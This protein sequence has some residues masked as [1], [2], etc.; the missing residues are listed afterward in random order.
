VRTLVSLK[1]GSSP[2]AAV[3]LSHSLQI[4]CSPLPSCFFIPRPRRRLC[5]FAFALLSSTPA[6]PCTPWL[7]SVTPI[8]SSLRRRSTWCVACSGGVHQGSPEGFAPTRLPSATLPSGSSCYSS[9]T[10]P[11][12]WRYRS[13]LS[14]YCCW[15]SSSSSFSTL[16]P[17][18]SSKQPSLSRSTRCS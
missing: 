2:R 3:T 5:H 17:T 11:A 16:R 1:K 10:S 6:P 12:G 18:P 13:R 4:A 14:S 9:P 15:R 7:C 8:A